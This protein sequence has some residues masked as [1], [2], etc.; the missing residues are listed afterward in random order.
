MFNRSEAL[1]EML[2]EYIC[3][4]LNRSVGEEIQHASD[5]LDLRR[6]D[7]SRPGDY[8]LSFHWVF[9]STV[10]S[11]LGVKLPDLPDG[12]WYCRTVG[13]ALDLIVAQIGRD[14]TAAITRLKA[15]MA[16]R[17][18]EADGGVKRIREDAKL[19]AAPSL[20]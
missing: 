10:T 16:A 6:F 18:A 8:D 20:A 17:A 9:P 19:N 13:R 3:D 15:I 12:A 7:L 11:E 1:R 14:R 4:T 2:R 5:G